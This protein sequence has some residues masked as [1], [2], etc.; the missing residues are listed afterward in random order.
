MKKKFILLFT[1]LS[2]ILVFAENPN[3]STMRF[4]K[5]DITEISSEKFYNG[6]KRTVRIWTPDSYSKNDKKYDV[7]YMHD[8]GNLFDT[9]TSFM[10]EEWRIDETFNR[11]ENENKKSLIVVGIDCSENRANEYSPEWKITKNSTSKTT[12]EFVTKPEGSEYVDFIIDSVKPYIDSN[13]RTNPEKN[14]TFIGGASM[15]GIISLFAALEHP[16]IFSSAIVFSPALHIYKKG[17]VEKFIKNFCKTHP[18]LEK[19]APKLYIYCGG[20]R[21]S[22]DE[23]GAPWDEEEIYPFA[24]KIYKTCRKNNWPKDKIKAV[25]NKWRT[26]SEGAW[27]A[28]FPEAI[29]WILN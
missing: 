19:S 9:Q 16:K 27:A 14:S 24:E 7:L 22:S 13:Y 5:L 20:F 12:L 11:F 29:E 21:K 1:F 28:E 26:H 25:S 18:D 3:L 10:G 2:S 23:K 6:K 8:G 15:G 4:G 17:T